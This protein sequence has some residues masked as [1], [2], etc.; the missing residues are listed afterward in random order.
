MTVVEDG[1]DWLVLWLAP[2]TPVVGSPLADGR[3]MREAPL[4]ER[5]R[6]PRV[7][8]PRLW[9]GTGI[10]KLVP[11][12]A[13]YSVWLF[14]AEDRRFL[15]WYGNLEDV[16]RRGYDGGVRVIDTVD[17]V[18]DVWVPSGEAPQWKD[19]DEFEVTTGLPGFWTEAEASVIRAQGAELVAT[20]ERGEAPFDHTWTSFVP[21]PS[22]PL[23][24]LP[25][26]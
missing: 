15:G 22:W 5:F 13:P 24:E 11:P 8:V 10:L 1:P 23:P 3:D 17:H 4:R 19:E 26:T 6:L 16:H 25:L 2:G 20:A 18:L 12:S 9:R 7:A 21:D 14:W